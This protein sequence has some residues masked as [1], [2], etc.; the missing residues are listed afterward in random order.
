[1]I[2]PLV[3]IVV[4]STALCLFSCVEPDHFTVG[5]RLSAP[6]V[7]R[8]DSPGQGYIW[9]EGDWFFNGGSYSW[10]DGYWTRPAR[11]YYYRPGTWRPKGQGWYWRPGR[12][13]R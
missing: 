11:G 12:W 10:R 9:I 4:L 2:I 8:P 6:I 3:K 5:T 1:M 7:I 13:R